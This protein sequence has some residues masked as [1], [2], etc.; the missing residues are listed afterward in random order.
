LI[1]QL[2]VPVA[3]LSSTDSEFART[4]PDFPLFF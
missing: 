2:V 4:K 3:R 1:G